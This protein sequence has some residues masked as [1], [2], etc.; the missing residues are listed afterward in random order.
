M[1]LP[2]HPYA[3]VGSSGNIFA[4]WY[5]CSPARSNNKTK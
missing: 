2:A 5:F 4:E 1:S 3:T